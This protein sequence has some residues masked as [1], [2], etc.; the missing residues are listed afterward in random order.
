MGKAE[1][2]NHSDGGVTE[3]QAEAQIESRLYSTI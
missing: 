1:C 3:P 2:I